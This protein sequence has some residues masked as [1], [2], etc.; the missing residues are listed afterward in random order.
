MIEVSLVHDGTF[1][2][3]RNDSWVARGKTLEDLDRA[4]AELLREDG[5]PELGRRVTVRM[6]F[7]RSVIPEWIRQ[8]SQHYFNRLVTLDVPPGKA[9]GPDPAGQRACQPR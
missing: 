4:V 9:A 3:A 5:N 1:W 7:D 2:V 8:Y 6:T